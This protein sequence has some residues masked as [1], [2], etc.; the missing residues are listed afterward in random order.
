MEVQT[1][2]FSPANLTIVNVNNV[3]SFQPSNVSP[4]PTG[5]LDTF[6]QDEILDLVAYIFR[7]ATASTRCSSRTNRCL[8][9]RRRTTE[10]T[11][12][13]AAIVQITRRFDAS[14]ERVFDAWLDPEKAGRWLFA[15]PTG[16]M[17]RA[18]IDAR[19]GGS[20]VFTDRRDNEDVEHL[21]TYLE[22]DRP[23]RLVFSFVVPKFSPQLTRVSID[24]RPLPTG[25]EITLSHEGV[26]PEYRDR[27]Q[28]GWGKILD[29]LAANL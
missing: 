13:A 9:F 10:M 26:L 25:C 21:G 11:L 2:M 15:T 1:D 22:I 5:L 27:A 20:F 6:R 19:V 4:M 14:I 28:D 18:E 12:D 29:A 17:V 7:A 3:D 16:Q 8:P 23:R 24:L